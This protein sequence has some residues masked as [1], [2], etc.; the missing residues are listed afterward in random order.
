MDLPP[1]VGNLALALM[2]FFGFYMAWEIL[3]WLRGNRAMLTPGQFR[4]RLAGAVLLETSLLMLFLANPVMHGRRAAEKLLYLLLASLFL[5]LPMLLAVR[6][7]AFV[8]RQ[9][10][11]WRG[12]L[13]QD[14]GRETPT[15]VPDRPA[16][17]NGP[18]Q[19]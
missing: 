6:E 13:V 18:R 15:P 12:D 14:L 4:R 3:R 16:P 10:A 17:G 11:R 5:I 19:G 9:Y 8:A 1:A 2:V 7:A